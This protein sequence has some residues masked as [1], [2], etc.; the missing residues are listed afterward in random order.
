MLALEVS[1]VR[2][3]TSTRELLERIAS[4]V[5]L[6]LEVLLATRCYVVRLVAYSNRSAALCVGAN[7]VPRAM[8][9]RRAF[10]A[11]QSTQ[12]PGEQAIGLRAVQAAG[13][14]P[15]AFD[16]LSGRGLDQRL[17]DRGRRPVQIGPELGRFLE[18]L[19]L[20]GPCLGA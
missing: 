4:E 16:D 10:A 1:S 19:R 6:L 17:V 14:A 13:P 2:V 12:D 3:L 5:L 15:P 9:A 8:A 18:A 11:G 7:F 20:S